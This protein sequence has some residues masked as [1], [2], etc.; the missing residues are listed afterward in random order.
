MPELRVTLQHPA[1]VPTPHPDP[2]PSP[3]PQSDRPLVDDGGSSA[4][5][6]APSSSAAPTNAASPPDAKSG[7]V[8]DDGMP[9][10]Q[11]SLNDLF[12]PEIAQVVHPVEPKPKSTKPVAEDSSDSKQNAQFLAELY[13]SHSVP[14]S[15]LSMNI[16]AVIFDAMGDVQTINGEFK[17][18]DLCAQ[19]SLMPRDLRKIDSATSQS[20]PA[21]LVRE[22]ALLL[23]LLHIRALIKANSVILLE[24]SSAVDPHHQSAFMH[25][26]QGKLRLKESTYELRALE[27]ILNS[28]VA[29]LQAD[30]NALV[31]Q[32]ETLLNEL[33][34]SINEQNLR[35]LLECRR[36]ASKL[37]QKVE[38]IGAALSEIL[39]SDEDLAGMYLTDKS[40]GHRRETSDHLEVELLIEH[41]T[42]LTNEIASTVS[43]VSSNLKNTQDVTNIVLA[44]QRNDLIMFELRAVLATLAVSCGSLVAS[45]FGMN[46]VTSLEGSPVAF[47]AVVSSMTLLI[48]AVMLSSMRS[49]ERIRP[50]R[51][52]LP[53][54]LRL[55]DNPKPIAPR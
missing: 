7:D 10:E 2:D 13:L 12:D 36:K 6:A 44:S 15:K 30:R 20:F 47:M 29:S 46:L 42:K 48:G 50:D 25:D 39:N 40:R 17:K 8:S 51:R 34:T 35:E 52:R 41:Y 31:N 19:H 22:K 5:K 3:Q 32:C 16:R 54:S 45:V 4:S 23:H 24:P 11:T 43:S 14:S 49:M 9:L 28:V 37:A 18:A 33:E 27:A 21:I 26:L 38:D 53:S 55:L 1:G